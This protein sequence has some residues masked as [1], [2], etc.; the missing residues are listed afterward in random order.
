MWEK[1]RTLPSY[2]VLTNKTCISCDEYVNRIPNPKH[3]ATLTLT[4]QSMLTH[5]HY[6]LATHTLENSTLDT[7][8]VTELQRILVH[9]WLECFLFGALNPNPRFGNVCAGLI[10]QLIVQGTNLQNEKE[11]AILCLQVKPE[12]ITM[13]Q[14]TAFGCFACRSSSGCNKRIESFLHQSVL[15]AYMFVRFLC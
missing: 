10:L 2:F 4:H 15:F 13:N 5:T 6:C 7:F 14:R 9:A 1:N 12:V 3:M 11:H 8:V